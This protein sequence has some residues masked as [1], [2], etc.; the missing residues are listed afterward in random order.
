[1]YGCKCGLGFLA[2]GGGV[3]YGSGYRLYGC[4]MPWHIIDVPGDRSVLV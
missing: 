3:S 4:R 1:M 2:C